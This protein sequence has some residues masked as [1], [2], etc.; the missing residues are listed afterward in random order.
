MAKVRLIAVPSNYISRIYLLAPLAQ[1][2]GAF[3]HSQ[4]LVNCTMLNRPRRLP[5]MSSRYCGSSFLA[6]P[7][8]G[9][10]RL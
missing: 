9:S 2:G 10:F 6:D 1:A 8:I 5:L 7:R 4:P 3:L